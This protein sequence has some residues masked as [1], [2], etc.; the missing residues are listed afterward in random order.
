M[1]GSA[2]LQLRVLALRHARH[3][4]D[5]VLQAVE[6]DLHGDR[7]AAARRSR[8]RAA[9]SSGVATGRR[10]RPPRPPPPPPG[11]ARLPA[12]PASSSLSGSSGSARPSSAPR[13]TAERL[14]R[15]RTTS[16]RATATQAEVGRRE[17]PEI[18]AARI[19]RRPDR[20]GEAVGDLLRLAGLD[21]ADEDRVIQRPQTARVGDPLRVGTPRPG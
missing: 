18:L 17:E 7:R 4:D 1:P 13:G 9:A 10:L 2:G 6:V 16:C 15:D 14:R 12:T 5:A 21:V 19:P 20:V 8:L 3:R 11:P